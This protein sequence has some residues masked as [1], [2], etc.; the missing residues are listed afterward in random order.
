MVKNLPANAGGTGLIPG[1]GSSHGAQQ[2][3]PC[4]AAT[5]VCVCCAY[6]NEQ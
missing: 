3:S 4:A 6:R 1:L 2:L 5:E